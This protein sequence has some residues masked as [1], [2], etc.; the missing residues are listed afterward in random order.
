M[1]YVLKISSLLKQIS[2]WLLLILVCITSLLVFIAQRPFSRQAQQSV[3]VFVTATTPVIVIVPTATA[4]PPQAIRPP[5]AKP[6]GQVMVLEYHLIGE[7][8]HELQRSPDNF[9]ADLERL[10]DLGYTP[11]NLIDLTVGFPN[12]GPG[13]RPIV[14]T[15][16]D[17]DVSQFRYLSDG[18]LDPASAVGMLYNFHLQHPDDWPLKGTFF[19]LQDVDAWQRNL[20]GQ[21]DLADQKLRWLV[22]QGFEIGSHTITHFDLSSGTEAQIQQE[23]ATSKW[24]LEAKLPGYEVH[25]FAVPFGSFPDNRSLLARGVW[26]GEVYRYA[27]TVMA[28]GGPTPSP[29][30]PDFDPYHIP[31]VV[32][33]QAELDYWLN[34]FSQNPHLYYVSARE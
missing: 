32:A 29:H 13:K 2:P 6:L 34:Y 33:T 15:F 30:S 21:A 24:R 4:T 31:R 9:Q 7:P 22:E 28:W 1:T 26:E 11:A 23:L 8:E 3:Q 5:Q 17:S 14:F 20:F 25:S 12:L 27:N 18:S 16:D 19:V 10:H